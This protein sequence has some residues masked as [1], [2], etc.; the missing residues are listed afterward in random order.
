MTTILEEPFFV[1]LSSGMVIEIQANFP[2]IAHFWIRYQSTQS[3][4]SGCNSPA[5]QS[6]RDQFLHILSHFGK[7][8]DKHR[9]YSDRDLAYYQIRLGR[10]LDDIRETAKISLQLS[11]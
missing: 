5:L 4:C 11:S 8:L 6:S 7:W 1:T 3:Q 9:G 10:A 2:E